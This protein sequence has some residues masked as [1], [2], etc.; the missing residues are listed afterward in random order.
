[1]HAASLASMRLVA[2]VAPVADCLG[3]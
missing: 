2:T 1:V 3:A